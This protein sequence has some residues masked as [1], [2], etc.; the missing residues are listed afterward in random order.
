MAQRRVTLADV[1]ERAGLSTTAASRVLNGRE[2]TRLSE[3]AR[4]RV[5]A[6]AKELGYRPNPAARSLRLNKTATIAL[7]SDTV[8]TTRFA[9]AMIRGALNAARE[10][11]HVVLITETQGD[12]DI[13]RDAIDAMLHRQVDGV[14]YAAMSSRRITVPPQLLTLPTVLLNATSNRRLPAVLPA[15]EEAA[16]AVTSAVLDRGHRNVAVLGRNEAYERDAHLSLAAKLRMQG[17]RK[18]LADHGHRLA[19]S[20][21]TEDWDVPGGFDGMTA[22]LRRPNRPTAVICMNDRL[23]VG[24]Y[25]AASE[26]GLS[27]PADL[28]VVSFDDDPIAEALRPGLT[29]AALPHEAMGQLAAELVL[30]A[31]PEPGIRWVPMPLR[32]RSSVAPPAG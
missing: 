26:A 22:L 8:V 16:Y 7:I 17:I 11:D 21:Y 32:E 3:D 31:N 10:R 13:E 4:Q 29:T 12:P 20:E 19:A 24:A 6:A 25:N 14:I 5:L 15:E 27:I 23:A 18:A 28:S 30:D 1:A 9:G 2:G